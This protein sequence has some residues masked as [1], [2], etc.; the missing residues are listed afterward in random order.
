VLPNGTILVGKY[1]NIAQWRS[2]GMANYAYA[3]GAK[4][5]KNRIFILQLNRNFF[6]IFFEICRRYLF[7]HTMCEFNDEIIKKKHLNKKFHMKSMNL[8]VIKREKQ[9]FKI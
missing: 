6:I 3:R 2:K 7:L 8:P 5:C 4:L 9:I 1:D